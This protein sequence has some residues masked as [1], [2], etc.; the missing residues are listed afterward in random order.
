M[1]SSGQSRMEF[2][3]LPPV[4]GWDSTPPAHCTGQRSVTN[5]Q[6]DRLWMVGG[7]SPHR[8]REKVRKSRS[9]CDTKSRGQQGDGKPSVGLPLETTATQH[10]R[11]A[12]IMKPPRP[13]PLQCLHG[14]TPPAVL[15]AHY[16][17]GKQV[18]T[19]Q[20]HAGEPGWDPEGQTPTPEQSHPQKSEPNPGGV[21][22]GRRP[23]CSR[24]AGIL[25]S[26]LCHAGMLI[27]FQHW[28]ARPEI[29]QH[30]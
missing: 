29:K 19:F 26:V 8:R 11:Q 1:E 2:V 7:E 13:P 5:N 3:Q 14:W 16:H 6:H 20:V 28:L 22:G 15:L 9:R 27:C 4:P 25:C 23:H 18:M 10:L 12:G 17:T 30:A 21:S 24:P